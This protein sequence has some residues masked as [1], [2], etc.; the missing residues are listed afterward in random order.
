MSEYLAAYGSVNIKGKKDDLENAPISDGA[1]ATV[2]MK[3]V[4]MSTSKRVSTSE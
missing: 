3:R 4:Y 1:N 2:P